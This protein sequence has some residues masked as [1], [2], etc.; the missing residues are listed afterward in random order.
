[1]F[2]GP[3]DLNSVSLDT[4]DSTV[5]A[6]CDLVPASFPWPS[7]MAHCTFKAYFWLKPWSWGEIWP[8]FPSLDFGLSCRP[9]CGFSAFR[10]PPEPLVQSENST[11]PIPWDWLHSSIWVNASCLGSKSHEG[12]EQSLFDHCYMPTSWSIS[13]TI[14]KWPPKMPRSSSW[15]LW[16][17]Y[18]TWQKAPHRCI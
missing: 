11:C 5:T 8:H 1:M 10:K 18:V 3:S 12:G 2:W 7:L 15:N 4:R 6:L 9:W 17:C 16:I 14:G 13:L